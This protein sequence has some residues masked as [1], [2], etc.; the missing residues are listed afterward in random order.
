MELLMKTCG[1]VCDTIN[2]VTFSRN[3]MANYANLMHRMPFRN[4]CRRGIVL[5]NYA[6]VQTI[7]A[8][9]NLVNSITGSGVPKMPV[10]GALSYLPDKRI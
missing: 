7:A 4:I 3:Y 5:A 10:G 8:N 1:E 9:G 6:N 2:P